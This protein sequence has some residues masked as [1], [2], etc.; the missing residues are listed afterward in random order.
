VR[1]FGCLLRGNAPRMTTSALVVGALFASEPARAETRYIFTT[2]LGDAEP[3]EKLHV[4]TS[5][6]GLNFTRFADTQYG[7]PTNVLRDPTIM[8]HSDG[9]YYIAYTVQ[10]WTTNSSTFGIASSED[11]REWTFLTEVPAGVNNVKFTWAPEWF[12]DD[13]GVHLIVNIGDQRNQFRSY[14]YKAIDATLL[15]WADPVPLG[16]GPNYIDT[17]VVRDGATYRAYTKNESTKFI[18]YATVSTSSRPVDVGGDGRLGGMGLR[19]GGHQ[20]VPTRRRHLAHVPR[21]LLRVR[22]SLR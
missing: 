7:G 3:E 8:K 13:D 12:K 19:Q 14:D 5:S 6:D 9:K 20:C 11:L 4:Y 18:E 2:F 17:F 22:L 15:E 10:S 21:L 16:I 1:D